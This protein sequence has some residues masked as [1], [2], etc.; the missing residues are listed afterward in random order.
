MDKFVVRGGNPLLGTVKISGAKNSALPC[1]AAA[2]LTAD[3]VILENIPQVRDIE[4]ERKLLES[5]GA[6]VE[7]G[8]GRAQHRTS[9]KCGILSDP[10]AKYEIV[11]TMR[12]SSLVLG[13]LIARTGIARVAM[14]GGCAIGGRP[15]D[16]HIKALEQMGATITYDHGYLEAKADRLKGTHIV[17]DKITVTGTEDIL[18]AATLAEGETILENS[19]REPEV[20]DLAALLIA[21]GAKIEGAGTSTIKIQGVSSLH[22]AR[23]RINPD[24]IEAGTFLIAGAITGG[25]LNVDCCDPAHLGS[26]IGKLEQAGARLDIGTDSIRVRSEGVGSLKA[27][28]ISTEEYP[29]FPTDMQAQYMALATQA[30]GTSIV[31]ENIFENRFM[32]VNE[33]VRM[34][35][36]IS[37]SGRT[38]TVRGR[39][40]LQ[41]AAVMCS[42]LRA[43]AAL[44][45]AALVADGESIL[46]RVYHMDRGYERM[47]EKLRGV[48]AQ[49]RRMGDVFGKR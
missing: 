41:S 15:I 25:D 35:A 6:E 44:V 49:I 5:M 9:I 46:D 23:Y 2:I 24:R 39:T 21:M 8:Y 42:D 29:G 14:P 18:M 16:L 32:H 17:F 13:P 26:L 19:A 11:K 37:V 20:T 10:V 28:D 27:V 45:L 38:A 43:S 12:A 40:P 30:E 7:L 48:G 36:N 3:E 4:T 34:G 22:G 31:T 1:M 47:E 33:L